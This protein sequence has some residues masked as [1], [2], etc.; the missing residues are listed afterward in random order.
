MTPLP[1]N[2][3]GAVYSVTQSAFKVSDA[4]ASL[5]PSVVPF[6]STP[7]SDTQNRVVIPLS[8]SHPQPPQPQSSSLR[9]RHP[10]LPALSSEE[11]AHCGDRLL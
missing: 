4:Q 2:S 9:H 8:C 3:G 5:C 11:S 1:L 10:A 7:K 6:H